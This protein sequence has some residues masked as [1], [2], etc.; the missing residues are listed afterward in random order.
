[1]G[2]LGRELGRLGGIGRGGRG[3]ADR[4]LRVWPVG[5]T[6]IQVQLENGNQARVQG[7]NTH[8]PPLPAPKTQ[9][10]MVTQLLHRYCH[11][12]RAA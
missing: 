6:R 5:S 4:W 7:T 3:G 10:S 9:H 11:R 12:C 8:D 1:V 2:H